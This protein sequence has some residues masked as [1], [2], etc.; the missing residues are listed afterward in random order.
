MRVPLSWILEHIA[1][2]KDPHEIARLLTMGGLEV[3][4]IETVQPDFEGVVAAKVVECQKHPNADKL[5]IASVTDGKNTYSVVCGA[6]NCRPG[7]HTAFA[8]VGAKLMEGDGKFFEVKKA[9]LRGVESEGMLCSSRELR[10]SDDAE[11]IIELPANIKEGTNLSEIYQETVFE[12]ALTPN[13][14]HCFS[15]LGIVRELAAMVGKP[16]QVPTGHPKEDIALPVESLAS[17]VVKDTKKCPRYACRVIR[18][19]HIAPSP[20][21]MQ[22]KL[23]LLGMRSVNN[24]VD[25]TNFVM[26]EMGQPIHAFDYGKLGELQKGQQIVVQCRKAGEVFTTLD[27]KKRTLDEDTLMICDRDKPVAIAGIMGGLESEVSEQTVDILLESAYFTPSAIRRSSKK[28]GIQTDASKR[29]E[30]GCDPNQVV[31]ALNRVAM[32]I[33]KM[34]GGDVAQGVIDDKE[35][36]FSPKVIACR[37][38]RVSQILGQHFSSSEIEN[39]FQRLR[40]PYVWAD[41]ETLH[42]EVPTYRADISAEIDLIEEI[43]RLYGYD[44]FSVPAVRYQSSTLPHAPIFLFERQMRSRLI[45]EGLQEF[46]TCDLISPT[47][48]SIVLN[49]AI[50]EED[51]VKVVNPTSIEQS[52]LRPSLLPGLIQLV[53]H[54]FDRQNQ[55][56]YG[57]EVGRIHLKEGERFKEQSVVGIILAGKNRPHH[58]DAKPK[59]TDFYDLKGM[60]ENILE[61]FGVPECTYLPSKLHVFH[62]GRQASISVNSLSIGTIG[63]IHPAIM[64]GFGLP[65]KLYYAEF[66]LHDLIQIAIPPKKMKEIPQFPSSARDWTLT[67]KEEVSIKEVFEAIYQSASSLLDEVSLVDIYRSDHLGKEQKSVTFHLVYL[68]RKKTILWEEADAEHARITENVLRKL[69]KAI[70]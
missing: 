9:K 58:W 42:V 62:P 35:G 6:P 12:V 24:V 66:N 5:T 48:V 1:I 34:A 32:L 4:A 3:E 49:K 14:G 57:F 70:I 28:L 13:L 17:V 67:I 30:R 21:W 60:I 56:I 54:N 40:F 61:E 11:G 18:G 59:E 44:N 69:G 37:I 53:Q 2:D 47:L 39:S 23:A 10:L 55:D 22:R 65:A 50:E 15:I 7:L 29:F 43:A 45:A 8:K 16:Y 33:Q 31:S 38:G 51:L 25:A 20:I 36:D 64:R 41:Q 26:M 68:N 46:L 19:V 63:E 52:I 27:G